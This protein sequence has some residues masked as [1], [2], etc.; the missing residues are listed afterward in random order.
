MFT[1]IYETKAYV[2]RNNFYFHYAL[3][4]P[5]AYPDIITVYIVKCLWDVHGDPKFALK[6][7]LCNIQSY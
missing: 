6:P 3:Q 1:S 2:V 5:T 7:V 4:L